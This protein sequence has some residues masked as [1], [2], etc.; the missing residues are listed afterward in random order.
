MQRVC[1][2]GLGLSNLMVRMLLK[3]LYFTRS[4]VVV[5]LSISEVRSAGSLVVFSSLMDRRMNG[6]FLHLLI[7]LYTFKKIHNSKSPFTSIAENVASTFKL[8]SFTFIPLFAMI[9]LIFKFHHLTRF[10]QKYSFNYIQ[11]WRLEVS[12]LIYTL[13]LIYSLILATCPI[14]FLVGLIYCYSSTRFW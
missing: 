7:L 1:Q 3:C 10:F 11:I 6:L 14:F 9:P 5:L 8:S 2:I 13:H 4:V 12:C